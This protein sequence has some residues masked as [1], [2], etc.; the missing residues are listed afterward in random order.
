MV[1]DLH[2]VEDIVLKINW[3]SDLILVQ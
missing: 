2:Y 3:V 1:T